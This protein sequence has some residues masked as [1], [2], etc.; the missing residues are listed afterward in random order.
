[1][2]VQSVPAGEKAAVGI[3]D[4]GIAPVPHHQRT[5]GFADFLVLW[6]DLGISFLLLIAG[7][8]LIGLA[9]LGL[10][11]ALLAILVG[12]V[13][14]NLLLAL[15]GIIGSD[16]GVPT[17]VMLRPLLGLRGSYLPTFFNV[18]QLIGWAT[19]EVY[20]MAR[21]ADAIVQ[22]ATGAS[23]YFFW[24]FLF[25]ALATLLAAGGPVAVVK[26]WMQRFAI[27]LVLATTLY[28]TYYV[29]A[30][31]NLGELLA[32]PGRGGSFWTGVDLVVALPVSWFPLVADYNRFARRARPAFWGTFAG[33]GIATVWFFGLGAVLALALNTADL[34]A[35]I[36]TL[37][38]GAVALVI[39]LVDEVDEGF[40]NI[41]STAV[42]IQNWFPRAALRPLVIGVG[43]LCVLLL[44]AGLDIAAYEI[45]LIYIGA[46][47]VP[48][49]GVLAADYFLLRNRR[50][51][52]EEA[53]RAGGPYAYLGGVNVIA[54]AVWGLGIL[55]YWWI[56]N[57]A[58]QIGATIPSFA[59]AFLLYAAVGRLARRAPRPAVEV[60]A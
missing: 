42:S 58:P 35:G 11:E 45:F 32:R 51:D 28:L 7:S 13:V 55:L 43:V 21:S 27:W 49:L 1:M 56:Y 41:Y 14:G 59:L 4:W 53:A 6:L 34:I 52:V 16:T 17:M 19:F 31:Y 8:L 46:I 24:V 2:A 12:A 36:L 20:I 60:S 57:F 33:Y 3:A 50:Y 22:S 23:T 47:F 25:A 37:A 26:R 30:N 48:L 38:F 29:L 10:G 44:A 18:V 9:G 39:I 15:A 5:L 40:A 54:I